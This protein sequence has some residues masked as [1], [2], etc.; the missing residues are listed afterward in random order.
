MESGWETVNACAQRIREKTGFSPRTALILGSGLGD[1]AERVISS[2]TVSY[3]ELPGFPVSTVSGHEGRFV[4]GFLEGEPV[5][6]MQGRVHYYEGYSMQ[7]VVLPVRVMHALGA[8]RLILTNAAGGISPTLSPGDLML[9]TDH[10]SFLVPSPLIGPNE[11]RFGP[12][13][14]DMSEVY[15]K[16]LRALCR[17][18]AL[19]AGVPL[20]EGVY[21]QVKGPQYETPAEIRA[22]AALGADAVGMSTACEAIA[23]GHLGMEVCGI[24]CITNLAAGLSKKPLSHEEVGETAQKTAKSF[25]SLLCAF[26]KKLGEEERD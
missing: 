17:E 22:F 2:K 20:R 19:E 14:P 7:E 11:P 5:I 6:V 12:R 15:S 8:K 21:L 26:L 1:F 9:L 10:V 18:A 4:L 24:S 13:F 16:R 23:A 3:R 25:Q